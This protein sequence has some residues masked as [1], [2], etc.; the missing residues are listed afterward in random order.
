M[1]AVPP[2]MVFLICP[3]TIPHLGAVACVAN[4]FRLRFT[5][6]VFFGMKSNGF[7]PAFWGV[8]Y[9]RCSTWLLKRWPEFLHLKFCYT[10]TLFED[11]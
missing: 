10:S 7:S 2:Q 3:L 1:N 8:Q 4:A 6:A 11:I 5:S 9:C